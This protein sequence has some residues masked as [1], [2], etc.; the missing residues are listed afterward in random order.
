MQ[1]ALTNLDIMDEDEDDQAEILFDAAAFEVP[2]V[3][4]TL[5]DLR[6]PEENLKAFVQIAATV[7]V[8]LNNLGKQLEQDERV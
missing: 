7:R 1:N 3:G 5:N 6:M 2:P 4:T 8:S